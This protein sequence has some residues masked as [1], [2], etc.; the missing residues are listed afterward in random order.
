MAEGLTRVSFYSS[1]REE[2]ESNVVLEDL[3]EKMEMD[4]FVT[5]YNQVRTCQPGAGSVPCRHLRHFTFF[6]ASTFRHL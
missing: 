3:L 5:L 2:Q 4:T 1:L 6:P